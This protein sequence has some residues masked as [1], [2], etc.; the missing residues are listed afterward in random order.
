MAGAGSGL[1]ASRLA[2]VATSRNPYCRRTAGTGGH[3]DSRV[4]RDGAT[5]DCGVLGA[6]RA[7]PGRSGVAGGLP[8]LA[9]AVFD[10]TRTVRRRATVRVGGS[11]VPSAHEAAHVSGDCGCAEWSEPATHSPDFAS[12]AGKTPQPT[13]PG[14]G[15][16]HRCGSDAT[17]GEKRRDCHRYRITVVAWGWL[18][19]GVRAMGSTGVAGG[20]GAGSDDAVRLLQ[21][22]AAGGFGKA[23]GTVAGGAEDRRGTVVTEA[24]R[25]EAA[26]AGGQC[27]VRSASGGG[28]DAGWPVFPFPAWGE[29]VASGGDVAAATG[30]GCSLQ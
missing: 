6:H 8:Q 18:V 1:T 10:S 15:A 11:V 4:R 12:G 17:V 30:R 9:R 28:R 3:P 16:W 2:G 19:G 5:A 13:G 22:M 25:S 20:N 24:N 26:Y 21:H 27:V 7:L 23:G 29:T 14:D